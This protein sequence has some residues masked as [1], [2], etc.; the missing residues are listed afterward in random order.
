L[1]TSFTQERIAG[2]L[3]KT[4]LWNGREL[5]FVEREVAVKITPSATAAQISDML[6]KVNATLRSPFDVLG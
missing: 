2:K 3:V 5:R 6:A 1:E 4:G